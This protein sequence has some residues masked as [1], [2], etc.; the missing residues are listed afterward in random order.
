M[1]TIRLILSIPF[2]IVYILLQFSSYFFEGFAMLFGEIADQI[3]GGP[4]NI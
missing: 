4:D 2:W 1:K 3:S